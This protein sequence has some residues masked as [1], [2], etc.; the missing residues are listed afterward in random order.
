MQISLVFLESKYFHG[1]LYEAGLGEKRQISLRGYQKKE[2]RYGVP[3][4]PI[5]IFWRS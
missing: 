4:L 3:F 1:A 5:A 2:H